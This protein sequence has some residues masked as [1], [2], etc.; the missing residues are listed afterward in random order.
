MKV[1]DKPPDIRRYPL[2]DP[3]MEDMMMAWLGDV[4]P[5]Q[6]RFAILF[7]KMNPMVGIRD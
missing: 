3:A 7:L 5:A 1:A 2:D 4:T 6:A